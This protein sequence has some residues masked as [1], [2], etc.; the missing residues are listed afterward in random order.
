VKLQNT[1]KET[2][3]VKTSDLYYSAWLLASGG[4]IDVVETALDGSKKVFFQ[5]SGPQIQRLTRE[6]LSG[7]A[8]AEC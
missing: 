8:T 4:R 6:Y 1:L 3:H 7:E 5:F 2:T